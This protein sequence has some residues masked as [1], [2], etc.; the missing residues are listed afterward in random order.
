MVDESDVFSGARD[1]N[2]DLPR[3]LIN[4]DLD[5]GMWNL[6]VVTALSFASVPALLRYLV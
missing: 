3:A 4:A 2:D 1:D 5:L 6:L